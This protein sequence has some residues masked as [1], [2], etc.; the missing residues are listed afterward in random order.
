VFFLIG[1]ANCRIKQCQTS[2]S[3][4]EIKADFMY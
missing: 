4:V 1:K 2:K 3:N